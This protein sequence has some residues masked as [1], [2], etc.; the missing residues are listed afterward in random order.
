MD[1]RIE[2]NRNTM[3]GRF[4][5]VAGAGELERMEQALH[6]MR[7]KYP[8]FRVD[9]ESEAAPPGPAEEEVPPPPPDA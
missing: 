8:D 7:S 6:D 1:I 2:R 3:S 5:V 9:G 4:E